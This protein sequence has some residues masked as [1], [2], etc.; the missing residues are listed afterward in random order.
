MLYQ[1][2]ALWNHI[3]F[4]DKTKQKLIFVHLNWPLLINFD[5]KIKQKAKS[6]C[7]IF[8]QKCGETIARTYN[9]KFTIETLS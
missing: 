9:K 7:D 3:D 5:D 6:H 2:H 4:Y 1:N 8:H